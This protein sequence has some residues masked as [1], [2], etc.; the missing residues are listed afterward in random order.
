M[1][2]QLVA[3]TASPRRGAR[4][5]RRSSSIDPGCISGYVLVPDFLFGAV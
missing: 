2:V 4:S 1:L 5:S 3:N